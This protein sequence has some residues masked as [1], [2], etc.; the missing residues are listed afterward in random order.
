MIF[1]AGL[2]WGSE[3]WSE[4]LENGFGDFIR[5]RVLPVNTMDRENN[6]GLVLVLASAA[7][8]DDNKLFEECVE[9]IFH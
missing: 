7:Y 4:K 1:A 5:E 6:W 8:L 9:E 3:Y 2:L